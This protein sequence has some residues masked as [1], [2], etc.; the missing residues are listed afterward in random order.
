MHSYIYIYNEKNENEKECKVNEMN[1]MGV[2]K[3]MREME[4]VE[5]LG[6]VLQMC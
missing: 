5:I 1:G 3:G 6:C 2:Y 4:C